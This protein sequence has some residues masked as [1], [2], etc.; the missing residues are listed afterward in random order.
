MENINNRPDITRKYK[1]AYQAA[2]SEIHHLASFR[3]VI[4][5]EGSGQRCEKRSTAN[6]AKRPNELEADRCVVVDCGGRPR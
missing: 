1:D 4:F 5:I 6:N 2:I 3:F